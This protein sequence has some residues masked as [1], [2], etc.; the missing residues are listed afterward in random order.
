MVE[1]NPR[2]LK[3]QAK[4][5]FNEYKRVLKISEKPDWEEF[6]MSAKITGAGIVI[7]GAM[8]FAFYILKELV[9]DAFFFA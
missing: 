2:K 6:S 3:N 8:G 9:L 4:S 7:I 5:K 1:T